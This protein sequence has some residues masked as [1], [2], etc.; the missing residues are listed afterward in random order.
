MITENVFWDITQKQQVIKMAKKRV[1]NFEC[2][3]VLKYTSNSL[4][5]YQI[6]NELGRGGG[7][8]GG[9]IMFWFQ[10]LVYSFLLINILWLL[11]WRT[12]DGTDM[13]DTRSVHCFVI[14][15]WKVRTITFQL[16][17]NICL[18]QLD[19]IEK[20]HEK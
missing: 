2:A 18:S 9:L 3:K 11:F 5:T 15:I 12:T 14:H 6:Y 8:S 13:P 20:V 16:S 17:L 10:V 19:L 4:K 1:C 7:E